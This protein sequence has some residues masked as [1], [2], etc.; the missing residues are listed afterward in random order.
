MVGNSITERAVMPEMT[1][2]GHMPPVLNHLPWLK[3]QKVFIVKWKQ[4][5]R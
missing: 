3:K 2:Y 5:G 1:L 4:W